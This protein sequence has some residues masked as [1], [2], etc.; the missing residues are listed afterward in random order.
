MV[1]RLD[2]CIVHAACRDVTRAPDTVYIRDHCDPMIT[3]ST[4]T[5][6]T[7]TSSALLI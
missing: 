3:E 7:A 2:E 5:M 4:H 1:G 6:N